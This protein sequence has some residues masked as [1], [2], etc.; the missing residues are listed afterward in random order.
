MGGVQ[1]EA[2]MEKG[3]RS[4]AGVGNGGWCASTPAAQGV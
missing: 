4:C 2:G 3:D 1:E